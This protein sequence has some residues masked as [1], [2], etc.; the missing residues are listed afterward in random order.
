MFL[1]YVGRGM[2]VR[3]YLGWNR[4][5]LGLLE[6]RKV[7]GLGSGMGEDFL[8]WTLGG[9]FR[10]LRRRLGGGVGSGYR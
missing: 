6:V 7:Y 9:G 8:N 1:V 5:F 3:V 2:D 4:G 10:F